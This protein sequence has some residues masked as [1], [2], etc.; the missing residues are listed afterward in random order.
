MTGRVLLLGLLLI[1][2]AADTVAAW[3]LHDEGCPDT[4]NEPYYCT[5]IYKP[6]CGTDKRTYRNLC[7]LCLHAQTSGKRISLDHNGAC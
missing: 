6:V 1:C 5:E 4:N 2:V 3:K 7:A